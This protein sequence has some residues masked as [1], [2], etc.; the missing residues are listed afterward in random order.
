MDD[1]ADLWEVRASSSF[2][3]KTR[4]LVCFGV[5]MEFCFEKQFVWCGEIEWGLV[6]LLAIRVGRR[7]KLCRPHDPLRGLRSAPKAPS[8]TD[9]LK[10]S[11]LLARN[12]VS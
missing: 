9:V 3:V 12:N 4:R 10:R 2:R 6:L 1:T 11:P 5:Y 7:G 8:A